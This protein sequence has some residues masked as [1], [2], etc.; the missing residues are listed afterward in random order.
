MRHE[1]ALTA[2]K[3]SPLVI[4]EPLAPHGGRGVPHRVTTREFDVKTTGTSVEII[5]RYC[6]RTIDRCGCARAR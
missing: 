4:A 6:Q 1:N 3:S 2:H 5:A